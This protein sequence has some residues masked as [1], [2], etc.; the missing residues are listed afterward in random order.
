MLLQVEVKRAEPREVHSVADKSH[1]VPSEVRQQIHKLDVSLARQ[2]H[3]QQL[4][5]Q[6]GKHA[7]RAAHR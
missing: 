2:L 1:L 5:N 7:K 6:Q 3:L 4:N